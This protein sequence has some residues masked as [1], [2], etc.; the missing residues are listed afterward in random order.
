MA[1]PTKTPAPKKTSA[2]PSVVN[3]TQPELSATQGRAAPTQPSDA[4]APQSSATLT[5][6]TRRSVTQEAIAK[7]AYELYLGRGGRG[8]SDVDD[9]LRAERELRGVTN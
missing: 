1:K 5:A 6:T 2:P 8:G 3:G 7:R 4:T 9:W